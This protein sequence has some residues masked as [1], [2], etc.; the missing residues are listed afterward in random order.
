MQMSGLFIC[1]L[2][3]HDFSR[4]LLLASGQQQAAAEDITADQEKAEK[5]EVHLKEAETL[6]KDND[7]LMSLLVP[8]A[9][10]KLLKEVMMIMMMIM[11]MMM[12]MM[13]M[14]RAPPMRTRR[15]RLRPS[16]WS[17]RTCSA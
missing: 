8:K 12:L 16:P 14:V 10:A 5:M 15:R 13:M 7:E 9:V 4:D 17:C 1:D 6:Q 11:M 3:M 2:A